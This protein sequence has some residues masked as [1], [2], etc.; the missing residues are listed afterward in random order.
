MIF[1][2]INKNLLYREERHKSLFISRIVLIMNIPDAT[3]SLYF[4][5]LNLRLQQKFMREIGA[6]V[7]T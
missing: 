5:L 3:K 7:S 6:I 2:L 1:F 4:T